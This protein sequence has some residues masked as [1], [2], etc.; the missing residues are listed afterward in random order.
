ME[1]LSH[2]LI[3]LSKKNISKLKKAENLVDCL[4][5][6]NNLSKNISAFSFEILYHRNQIFV[7]ITTQKK[8]SQYIKS[9]ILASYPNIE[10]RE[11]VDFLNILDKN[12]KNLF[13]SK[14]YQSTPFVF[15]LKTYMDFDLEEQ[16]EYSN[17][18]LSPIL[19]A[20]SHI[21]NPK[22]LVLLQIN[23][24]PCE[25]K[26]T[27]RGIKGLAISQKIKPIFKDK[28]LQSYIQRKKLNL[29]YLLIWALH[30][31]TR[32]KEVIAGQK[33]TQVSDEKN[34]EQNQ[35]SHASYKYCRGADKLL[36]KL[37]YTSINI[38]IATEKDIEYAKNIYE[39]IKTSVLG[40]NNPHLGKLKNTELNTITDITHIK[41]REYTKKNILNSE[42][43]CSMA[44]IPLGNIEV[45]KMLWTNYTKLEPP[46]N[47][48]TT[49]DTINLGYTDYHSIKK[50]FGIKN[51]DIMRHMYIMGSTGMGKSTLLE[52]MIN[53]VIHKNQGMAI[54]D[55]HG[56]LAEK[57][58]S[59]V[60]KN[61]TNDII[62]FDPS[63]IEYP[64]AYNIMECKNDKDRN[65]LASG[66]IGVFQKLY[67]NSWGPRLEHI[68]RNTVLT[69]LY[70][71]NTSILSIPKILNNKSFRQQCLKNVKDP[72]LL[73]FWNN[74]YE[75][76]NPKIKTEWI[77]PILNKVGQF[78]SNPILRNILGQIKSK[79]HIRWAMDTGKIL[80]INLSKG[81][82]GEDVS[83]LL[84]SL[85]ITN[86][87]IGAMSRADIPTE[88]RK[89]FYLFI[90]EFQN[91]ATES[92]ATILSEARKYRLSLIMANQ[93]LAQMNEDIRNAIFGNV[94]S[95]LSFQIGYEDAEFIKKQFADSIEEADLINLQKGTIYT[96]LLIDGIPSKTFSAKTKPPI[97]YKE[98]N[99]QI[100]KIRK[101]SREKYC[102]KKSI[103]EEKIDKWS[104][105][106]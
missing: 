88:K 40:F 83:I 22:D 18:T 89:D 20:F 82:I 71:Q 81:K 67:A 86:F 43:L 61:R 29:S 55:P 85:L 59:F 77:S 106:N 14:I 92:F 98:D 96:K 17:D 94:G 9:Q 51:A 36:K 49:K 58:L 7:F 30:G 46:N 11:V 15:P 99:I 24:N 5:E 79:F 37:F 70:N 28:F 66:I 10:I 90:D 104:K 13:Y 1:K 19:S 56:D 32:G 105:N 38:L 34:T 101:F 50:E 84:G 69:L 54:I 57:V 65:L 64:I 42:E 21:S 76:L 41:N 78:L 62:L 75:P 35:Q 87:Q 60:P 25:D 52:N 72:V 48:P 97:A 12:K 39:S 33:I 73:D 3:V 26:I 63:D 8:F 80:I 95:L 44:H 47:L 2:L 74:E 6:I 53:E 27:R 16:T 68:L 93:Y 45:P 100:D 103:I 91:F 31:F 23:C 102:T 4:Y